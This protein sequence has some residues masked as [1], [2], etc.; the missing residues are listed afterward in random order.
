MPGVH[1]AALEHNPTKGGDISR[2]LFALE[3]TPHC[4]QMGSGTD[5]RS[6]EVARPALQA[7]RD[8]DTVV[9]MLERKLDP[10]QSVGYPDRGQSRRLGRLQPT[11]AWIH[12]HKEEALPS[13]LRFPFGLTAPIQ[14]DTAAA[15]D[16]FSARLVDAIRDGRGKVLA[17]KG[18]VV[19]GHLLRVQ[20]FVLH[21]E[22]LVVLK[23]E[24][25]WVRGA[26]VPLSAERDWTRVLAEGRRKGKKS[27][28]ILL[29]L[30][31]EDNSGVFGFSVDHVTV[32]TRY[33]CDWRTT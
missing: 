7:L 8:I 18:T 4:K 33:R 15:G 1:D 12:V 27:L 20:R 13:G 21:P 6:E 25:L 17:P 24:A 32:P 9:D 10:T 29:P 30:R 14:T 5:R 11:A 22:V 28:E 31:G 19:E 16:P 23:P 26:R 2:N 3:R